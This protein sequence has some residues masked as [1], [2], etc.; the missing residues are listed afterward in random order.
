M[1]TPFQAYKDAEEQLRAQLLPTGLKV[2]V[3]PITDFEAYNAEGVYANFKGKLICDRR[4][5]EKVI[6]TFHVYFDDPPVPL[7]YWK[8]MYTTVIRRNAA[9][10]YPQLTAEE[11]S[12]TNDTTVWRLTEEQRV[13]VEKWITSCAKVKNPPSGEGS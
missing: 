5:T 7:K 6:R 1:S 11:R 4:E 2:L 3:R 10:D 13:I 12:E 8:L 9:G